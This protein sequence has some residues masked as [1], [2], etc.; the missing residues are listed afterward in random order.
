MRRTAVLSWLVLPL[1]V[2]QAGCA[3]FGKL[4]ADD[5]TFPGAN[6][7]MP[8]GDAENLRRARGEAASDQPIL[9]QGGNMWPGP[10][11]PLPTLGDASREHAG[12]DDGLPADAT[13]SE[14]PEGGTLS[15]GEQAE[16]RGGVQGISGTPP[17]V[18]HDDSA[19]YRSG[20][21][22][23]TIVIPNGDGT[24]TI[25][26]PDGTVKTVKDPPTVPR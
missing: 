17:A 24:S 5:A 3:G 26:A 2:P 25:I 18:V 6:P 22:A 1:L 16:I 13:G 21:A 4:M 7:N 8:V 20:Q 11:A 12:P 9:P 23:S 10:P 14:L 19:R 15:A